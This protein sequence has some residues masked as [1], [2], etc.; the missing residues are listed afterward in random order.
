MM[1]VLVNLVPHIIK[2]L[3]SENPSFVVTAARYGVVGNSSLS[4]N[5]LW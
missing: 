1:Q 4:S 5:A 3:P 2:A